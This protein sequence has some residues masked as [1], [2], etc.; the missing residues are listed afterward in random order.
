MQPDRTKAYSLTECISMEFMSREG[1]SEVLKND[2][3]FT[4]EEVT[5]L[6]K[7]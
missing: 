1:L 7:H 5:C 3:H 6:L 4:Q 2:D